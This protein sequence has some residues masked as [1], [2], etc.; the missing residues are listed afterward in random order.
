V[1]CQHF[2]FLEYVG[3]GEVNET[4]CMDCLIQVYG[5]YPEDSDM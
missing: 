2:F 3:Q 4:E 5:A 1:F